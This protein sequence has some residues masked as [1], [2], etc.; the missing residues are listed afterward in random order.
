M[1]IY[2]Y[3]WLNV[4]IKTKIFR[5][6]KIKSRVM[7]QKYKDIQ[8]ELVSCIFKLFLNKVVKKWQIISKEEGKKVVHTDS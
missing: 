7:Y 5:L 3:I 4:S 8:F 1:N 6:H 2:V